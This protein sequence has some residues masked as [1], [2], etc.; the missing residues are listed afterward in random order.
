MLDLARRVGDVG[1]P[2]DALEAVRELRRQLDALEEQYV[3]AALAR[4]ASW[5]V[6]GSALGV[7]RQAADK[8]LAPRVVA[9]GRRGAATGGYRPGT[10]E[11]S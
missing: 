6:I 7:S 8:R 11:S 1:D 10:F 9:G 4:G 3:R 2:L 5:D